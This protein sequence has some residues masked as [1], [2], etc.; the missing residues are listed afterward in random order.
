MKDNQSGRKYVMSIVYEYPFRVS[1]IKKAIRKLKNNKA[2]G[3]DGIPGGREA[4]SK[5]ER[6]H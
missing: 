6:K 4:T 3:I 2:A 5:L 1:E